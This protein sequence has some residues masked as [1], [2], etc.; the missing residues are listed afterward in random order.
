[1]NES[2]SKCSVEAWKPVTIYPFSEFY[3]VSD[4]G[5]IKSKRKAGTRYQGKILKLQISPQGYARAMLR[6]G[7]RKSHYKRFFQVHRLVAESFIGKPFDRD[8]VVNHKNHIKNDNR[9]EN[10][11]WTTKSDNTK[12]WHRFIKTRESDLFANS[13]N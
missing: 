13:V 10:L 9:V 8:M 3:E 5:R 1:M 11:E 7:G 6:V 4:R 12:A 2:K